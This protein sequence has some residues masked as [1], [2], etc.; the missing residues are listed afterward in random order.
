[1]IRHM[2]ARS[3]PA[4]CAHLRGFEGIVGGEMNIKEENIIIE[5]SEEEED[6]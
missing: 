1:M 2:K 3:A 6:E 5:Q 4:T